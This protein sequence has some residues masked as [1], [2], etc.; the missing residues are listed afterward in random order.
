MH[1]NHARQALDP[2]SSVRHR[3]SLVRADCK[4]MQS[5]GYTHFTLER[6]FTRSSGL[7][8]HKAYAQAWS[9]S[10]E[11]ESKIWNFQ[12]RT[13][14]QNS[15]LMHQLRS[16]WANFLENTCKLIIWHVLKINLK[17]QSPKV[18]QLNTNFK[19]VFMNMKN[20]ANS[21][22]TWVPR[23]TNATK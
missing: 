6:H 18:V 20:N 17:N 13:Q 21:T 11:R 8:E 19:E 1:K 22:H 9:Y 4:H 16:F 14:A 10:L 7:H 3:S 15:T 12:I 2:R 23:N 5:T